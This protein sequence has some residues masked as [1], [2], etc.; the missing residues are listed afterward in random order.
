[1][2]Y[3]YGAKW[4]ERWEELQGFY[5]ALFA[6]E[7]GDFILSVFG[8]SDL[9]V[10]QVLGTED[11]IWGLKK[12]EKGV[13]VDL[14]VEARKRY[15]KEDVNAWA[16]EGEM[17]GAYRIGGQAHVERLYGVEVHTVSLLESLIPG[18]CFALVPW[19]GSKVWFIKFILLPLIRFGVGASLR[20]VLW[21]DY[22]PGNDIINFSTTGVDAYVGYIVIDRGLIVNFAYTPYMV[23]YNLPPGP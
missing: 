13:G 21:P 6:A 11:E 15:T 8:D 9:Y 16:P 12:Y 5:Y 3:V 2:E 22:A 23:Y 14:G 18:A 10:Y 4:Y 19:P 20:P 7:A 1:M 17:V